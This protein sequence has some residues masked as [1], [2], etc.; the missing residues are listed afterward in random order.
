MQP[1]S[2]PSARFASGSALPEVDW[3]TNVAVGSPDRPQD[4]RM[5][6]HI[7]ADARLSWYDLRPGA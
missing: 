6:R 2:H 4:A 7:C 1:V 3:P 5:T